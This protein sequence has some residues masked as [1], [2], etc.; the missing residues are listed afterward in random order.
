M[1]CIGR[2]IDFDVTFNPNQ[3][4]QE[5]A[6]LLITESEKMQQQCLYCFSNDNELMNKGI[7]TCVLCNRFAHK[8]CIIR[9]ND[10]EACIAPLYICNLRSYSSST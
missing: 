1:N 5:I 10:H 8:R 7:I 2:N 3:Y 9:T 4:R 6:K